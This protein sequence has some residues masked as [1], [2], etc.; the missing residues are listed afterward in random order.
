[1]IVQYAEELSKEFELRM[2]RPEFR[3]NLI[4]IIDVQSLDRGR[5]RRRKSRRPVVGE[6]TTAN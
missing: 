5:F 3:E 6:E 1:M 4:A 2:L